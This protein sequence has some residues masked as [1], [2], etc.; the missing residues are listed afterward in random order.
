MHRHTHYNLDLS[1]REAMAVAAVRHGVLD[2]PD[3]GS[4]E[5]NSLNQ[6]SQ[7][8]GDCLCTACTWVDCTFSVLSPSEE[9][10]RVTISVGVASPVEAVTTDVHTDSPVRKILAKK[11]RIVEST[12]KSG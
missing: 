6:H 12:S 8:S 10:L 2:F 7:E 5:Y 9:S 11:P 1:V 3:V 4:S